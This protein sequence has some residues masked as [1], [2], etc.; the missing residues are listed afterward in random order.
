MRKNPDSNIYLHKSLSKDQMQQKL[1]LYDATII[2]LIKNIYGAFPSKITMAMAA[3]LPIIFS[4]NGEGH[5][6]VKDF[7]LGFA[8]SAGD[9]DELRK[10]IIKFSKLDNSDI[11][12]I[13]KNINE[14]CS[15][16]FNFEI[17]QLNLCEYISNLI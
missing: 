12:N 17:Q 9:I 16:D 15:K 13:R 5:K 10:N 14:A 1:I 7:K 8:S 2:P 6:I 3:C 11:A 4:G